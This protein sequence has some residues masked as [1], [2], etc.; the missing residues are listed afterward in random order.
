MNSAI[1]IF[2]RFL[3]TSQVKSI[4]T[5]DIVVGSR[6][7]VSNRFSNQFADNKFVLTSKKIFGNS[8]FI[9]LLRVF[10]VGV[11]SF[12]IYKIGHTSGMSYYAQNKEGLERGLLNEIIGGCQVH[13]PHSKLQMRVQKVAEPVIKVAIKFCTANYEKSISVRDQLIRDIAESTSYWVKLNK[14]IEL[15]FAEKNVV[16]SAKALVR[17]NGNWNVFIPK[18]SEISACVCTLLP[19]TMFIHD[20]FF[21][22]LDFNDDEL[23]MMIGHE[24]SHVILG[25]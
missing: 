8:Y 11:I 4:R 14:Q 7:F 23:A 16:E 15:H 10:R 12:G 25:E 1:K 21:T 19:H 20:G 17:V 13:E 22:L 24:L 6:K 9:K 2:R 5:F 3:T 18:D